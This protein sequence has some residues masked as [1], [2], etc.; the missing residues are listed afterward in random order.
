M[1]SWPSLLAAAACL[2]G[3]VA[4][5]NSSA[6]LPTDELLAILVKLPECIVSIDLATR[7]SRGLLTA[8]LANML[9]CGIGNRKLP[10]GQYSELSL[11]Q[12]YNAGRSGGVR[13][14][15]MQC[16]RAS[17]YVS[18]AQQWL[19]APR[20]DL[21]ANL[22]TRGSRLESCSTRHMPRDSAAL[23]Q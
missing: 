13:A 9:S 15:G 12:Q 7:A 8:G 14:E 2:L 3:V 5:Q 1:V 16:Y 22:C 18:A 19:P 20:L 23:S 11:H 4:A 21:R 17:K 6:V 10:A